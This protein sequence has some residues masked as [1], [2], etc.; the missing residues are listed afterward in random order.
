MKPESQHKV[1]IALSVIS[2]RF[3]KD[4]ISTEDATELGYDTYKFG[5]YGS[6]SND[7]YREKAESIILGALSGW[8]T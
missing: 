1:M 8:L 5:Y 4:N 7:E 2:G 3:N 6:P